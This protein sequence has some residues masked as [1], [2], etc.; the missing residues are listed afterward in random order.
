MKKILSHMPT[1]MFSH[2]IGFSKSSSSSSASS[3]TSDKSDK[4]DRLPPLSNRSTSS[5]SSDAK[6]VLNADGFAEP[7]KFLY[8]K[9][10]IQG[11]PCLCK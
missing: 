3:T 7:K 6:E 5:N 9:E 1:S 4:S 8:P 2:R 10:K 11:I